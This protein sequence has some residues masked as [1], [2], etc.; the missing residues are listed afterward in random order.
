MNKTDLALALRALV[1][2]NPV[3]PVHG[4]NSVCGSPEESQSQLGQGGHQGGD[5]VCARNLRGMSLPW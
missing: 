5:A 4:K 2:H 1:I 3:W